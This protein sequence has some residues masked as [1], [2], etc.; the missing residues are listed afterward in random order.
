VAVLLEIREVISIMP[1]G[2]DDGR[3]TVQEIFMEVFVTVR[4]EVV[5]EGRAEA[6]VHS[7]S[8]DA[9]GA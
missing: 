3:E 7:S 2:E 1:V 4:F 6:K 9:A 8:V 5:L